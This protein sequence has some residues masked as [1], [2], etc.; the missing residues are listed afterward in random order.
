MIKFLKHTILLLCC[1]SFV[2]TASAQR[3]TPFPN[4]A[5]EVDT[6]KTDQITVDFSNTFEYIMDGDSVTQRL[7][8]DVE[9]RQDSI[10]MYCD[11]ASIINNTRV[12]AMGNVI[13]QQGDSTSVFADSLDYKGDEKKAA[14]FGEVVL[15]DKGQELFTKQ[16]NYDLN[17]KIATYTT[18][19][20]LNNNGTQ[21]TSKVGYYFV[22]TEEAFFKD[23]VVVVDEDFN[24]R[25]D[26]LKFNT[27]TG[28][29]TFLGPTLINSDSSRIYCE[30]GFYDTEKNEAEFTQ[31]AQFLKGS[32][33]AVADIITYNGE[34]KEYTLTG[35]AKFKDGETR[36]TADVIRYD[37][38]NDKTILKGNAKY[39]D[40]QQN[41]ESDEIIYDSA[42][43]GFATKGRS[44]ISDPP[45]IL[46]A[47]EVDYNSQLGLGVADGN[48]IWRDTAQNLTI[49]SE[50]A[51]Y[52]KETDYFKASG[53]RP[54]LITLMDGDSLFMTSDTLV[55]M[56]KHTQKTELVPTINPI[57]LTISSNTSV[58]DTNILVTN[59]APPKPQSPKTKRDTTVLDETLTTPTIREFPNQEEIVELDT[60]KIVNSPQMTTANTERPNRPISTSVPN[61]PTNT[62]FDTIAVGS[63]DTARIL[64]AFNDVRIF[65]EN[66]QA[67]CDSL[68]YNTTDSLFVFYD[69][70]I[71]WSDTSQFYADTVT[72]R[73]K[74]KKIDKIFLYNN[75]FIINSP[76]E[77]FFNQIKGKNI[78]AYFKNEELRRMKVMGN[79]ESIYYAQDDDKAYIGM[80]K[81]D[82][83]EMMVYFGNNEVE[84]IK[85]IANPTA[86]LTPMLQIQPSAMKMPGFIWEERRRPRSLADLFDSLVIKN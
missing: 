2:L 37:E 66:L 55:A 43:E 5:T 82:A 21:L 10:Y 18:G 42:N 67:V 8:G 48:V 39:Q 15:A 16:L 54:L 59:I 72:M 36:A 52:N 22:E 27:K 71:I 40:G 80:N 63:P 64:L 33:E 34:K 58:R 25:S 24:L 78:T 51:N 4:Q 85:F 61:R 32:Q 29:V 62:T 31:N 38:A 76:D 26:T 81:T 84:R 49:K 12:I 86:L 46:E 75:A 11:S 50:H 45:Q 23:S 79:A 7:V 77:V 74:N 73:L 57:D 17:T 6:S 56:T 53:G 19:A 28:V 9:L 41:I 65:K 60:T 14:L 83:S 68:V 47:D 44:F 70:P 3:P 1:L 30:S 35:D 69:N 13:I 20:T